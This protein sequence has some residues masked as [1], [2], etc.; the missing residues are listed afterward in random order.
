LIS[1]GEEE[2]SQ[3]RAA[4]ENAPAAVAAAAG[5]PG[6]LRDFKRR[7]RAKKKKTLKPG[8]FVPGDQARGLKFEELGKRLRN[9]PDFFCFYYM[10]A[11]AKCNTFRECKM[12]GKHFSPDD[13]AL[14]TTVKKRQILEFKNENKSFIA[15]NN[16]EETGLD[17]S[18]VLS[19]SAPA[20]QAD[21]APNLAE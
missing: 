3:E 7:K 21:N 12:G 20:V 10:C 14:L 4:E 1:A 5:S 11:G 17:W 6:T 16:N 15:F 18:K 9:I 19:E 2:D 8:I 13:V